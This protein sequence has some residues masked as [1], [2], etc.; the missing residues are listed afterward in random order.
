MSD[1]TVE[2]GWGG[3]QVSGS[4]EKE[5]RQTKSGLWGAEATEKM[6]NGLGKPQRFQFGPLKVAFRR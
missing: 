3:Q 4:E 6:L 2:D 5:E 1:P